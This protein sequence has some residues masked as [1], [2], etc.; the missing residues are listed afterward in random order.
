MAPES[1]GPEY[2]DL[3]PPILHHIALGQ[4]VTNSSWTE[5]RNACLEL[6]PS[7]ESHLW[8]DEKASKFVAEK[9]PH[10]KPMWDGYKYPIQRVDA[11]RYMVL[12]EYGG[13][14]LDMDLHCLRSLGPLRRFAFVAP[15]AHP[16]GFSN[17]MML[18]S[19][20]HPFVRQLVRNLPAYDRDWFWLP[21]A[22]VM[23]STGCHY[24]SYAWLSLLP[25]YIY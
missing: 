8:T 6:H 22:T 2:S 24:A 17:G 18:A 12:Q 23:F 11:L 9:Y 4:D 20:H 3:I 25:A 5:A 13:A 15:A 19:K 21:Y 10:L 1:A 7:W 16:I 14:V